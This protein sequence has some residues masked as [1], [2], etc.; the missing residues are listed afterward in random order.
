ML[1]EFEVSCAEPT[2]TNEAQWPWL[3]N[4]SPA[5]A[6]PKLKMV[7]LQYANFKW[8]SPMFMLSDLTSINIRALPTHHLTLDRI[9]LLISSNLRLE[10]L[11]LFFS[12]VLTA[13]LPL[14]P[15]TLPELKDLALGGHYALA[16]LADNLIVPSLTTL[17]LDIEGRD[18]IEETISSLL[19][20]S[21]NPKLLHFSIAYG[22]A[23]GPFFYGPSGWAFLNDLSE[24]KTLQA[25]GTA[26][27]ALLVALGPPDEDLSTPQ[28]LCPLLETLSIK[29]CHTHADGVGKLVD[30]VEARNPP[31]GTSGMSV[32]GVTPVRL[33]EL[34][35]YE[36]ANLGLD[37]VRWLKSRVAGFMCNEVLDR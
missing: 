37:V 8:S 15:V 1:R 18:P 28:W 4:E 6:L 23:G 20:R 24:L 31:P 29:H 32:D 9:L 3:P 17:S 36:S 7:T 34:Q 10:S 30:L 14:S 33:K 11:S 5:A 27:E 13:I 16:T 2:F 35:V 22:T 21:H 12:A 25:G 26:L 19:T